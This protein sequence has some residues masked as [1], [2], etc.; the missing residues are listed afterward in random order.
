M[1]LSIDRGSHS[2]AK[3]E[4]FWTQWLGEQPLSKAGDLLV[5]ELARVGW[6]VPGID[7]LV[8][9]EGSGKSLYRKVER[10]TGDIG[11]GPFLFRF[12]LPTDPSDRDSPRANLSQAIIPPGLAIELHSDDSG[13]ASVFRGDWAKG[14][15]AFI[16]GSRSATKL[17]DGTPDRILYERRGRSRIMP[18]SRN[19]SRSYAPIGDE[20]AFL[21]LDEV[22][23]TVKGFVETILAHL[24]SMPD[25]EHHG[26]P[27]AGLSKLLPETAIPVPEGF[28][29]LYAWVNRNTIHNLLNVPERA[30]DDRGIG[31]S[32][33]LASLGTR[34]GA[35]VPEIVYD[36]FV[37]ASTDP[38]A[39][40]GQVIH[41]SRHGDMP[42]EITLDAL[43]E[44]YVVD[45]AA[46]E[47]ARKAT[48]EAIRA[49][50]KTD[51]MDDRQLD[52]CVLATARTIV[53]VLEYDGSFEDPVHVIRRNLPR[54]LLRV[55]AGPVEIVDAEDGVRVEMTDA[56]TDTRLPLIEYS[57]ARRNAVEIAKRE[58]GEIE[59]LIQRAYRKPSSRMRP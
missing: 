37:Y 23:V 1:G 47:K 6:D 51:R 52:A 54:E 19:F 58:A 42:V 28:P 16:R 17:E 11:T 18:A 41:G 25:A 50:G 45:N 35:P 56:A 4:F 15:K 55:M 53:P 27:D 29:K 40:A 48:L 13:S 36:G 31:V 3:A 21:D 32:T 8:T 24:K 12:G 33:R 44:V 46:F 14:G 10:I 9:V 30:A 2:L 5:S 57:E 49:E 7:V 38:N 59:D 22:A 43:N 26:T 20:P 34:D 39:R